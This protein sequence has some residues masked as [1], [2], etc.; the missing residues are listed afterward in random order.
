MDDSIE[1]DVITPNAGREAGLLRYPWPRG[2]LLMRT[3]WCCDASRKLV[4]LP[5]RVLDRWPD[6]SVRW[7]LLD[8]IAEANAGPYRGSRRAGRG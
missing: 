2:K 6:G 7:V 1:L 8:W 4:P 3:S 5:S